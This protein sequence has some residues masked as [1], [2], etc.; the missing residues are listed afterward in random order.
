MIADV[1]TGDP[2]Q[3]RERSSGLY[4]PPLAPGFAPVGEDVGR[5]PQRQT[6]SPV[7][8]ALIGCGYW[9]KN[10]ARSLSALDALEVVVDPD[11]ETAEKISKAYGGRR[12]TYEQALDDPAVTAVAIAAPAKMHF[13]LGMQALSAGKHVF[14]EKPLASGVAEAETLLRAAHAGSRVLM[15]GHLLHYHQGYRAVRN[16]VRSGQLGRIQYL[17]SNRLSL[18]RVRREEDVLWSFAPHDISMVLDL[19]EEAPESVTATGAPILHASIRDT[20][21]IHLAFPSGIK[22]HVFVSWLHPFKEQRLTVIGE[23]GAVVFDDTA[24][25]ERKVLLFPYTTSWSGSIPTP[26]TSGGDAVAFPPG[27]PLNTELNHFLECC[28]HGTRPCTDGFEAL[29]VLSVLEQAT[30]SLSMGG[31]EESRNQTPSLRGVHVDPTAV[32]DQDVEIGEGSRIWHFSHILKGS[33]LGCNVMLGQNV[34][35][36]PDV[37]IGH[38][39]KVQ[40][41][42]SVYRGVTLEDDVFCGPSCVFTNVLD[43][44][45]AIERKQEFR[46][47]L[48]RRG[49]TIGA[50]ATILC[51]TV[52]GRYAFVAAG[53]VVTRNV[54]D[55]AL[56]TGVPARHVGWVSR[57]GRRLGPDLVC[58]ETG[59]RYQLTSKGVLVEVV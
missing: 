24:L 5:S 8:V 19:I 59:E 34:M 40:N 45:A 36:G 33:R 47:T 23:R 20:C 13:Q 16:I 12:L 2:G 43:P 11:L 53:A 26:K 28:E 52:I 42:V 44:R 17:Y 6:T 46:E 31:V 21:N 22:A 7:R 29:R 27:E 54:P 30:A 35:V 48:V 41:N 4:S 58:P 14:V 57:S 9:G 37:Q 49:A 32:I 50:N 51:G 3:F 10:I 1:S 18:G 15:V 38:A 25:P 55:F 39:V 56:V